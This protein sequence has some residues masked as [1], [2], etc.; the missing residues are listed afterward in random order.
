MQKCTITIAGDFTLHIG[1]IVHIDIG[2]LTDRDKVD[3]FVGG[4]Y[5]I[6]D[7]CHRMDS[8]GVFTKLNL[9]RDTFKRVG[10]PK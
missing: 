8:N 5:L 10:K 3:K 2:S 9:S 6:L 1:D 7:L 4:R